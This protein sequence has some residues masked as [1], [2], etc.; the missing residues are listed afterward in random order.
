LTLKIIDTH[1]HL[2]MP[3]FDADREDMIQRAHDAGVYLI[4]TI[5][6]DVE[7]SRKAIELAEQH[8]GI[9][10]SVGIH[11]Q[12]AGKVTKEDIDKLKEF[13]R[14][15]KVVAIGELGLDYYH[16]KTF[17]DS[18]I[19]VLEWE[20]KLAEN[21]HLPIIIHCREAQASLMPVM[22]EWCNSYKIPKG[23]ARGVLHC[24]GS[25]IQTAEWYIERGFYISIGAYVG[26]PSSIQL[27]ETLKSVPVDRLVVETDCPFLPPQKNRGKRNEPA[28]TPITV[29]VLADIKQMTVEEMAERTTNNAMALFDLSSKIRD[30]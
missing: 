6:I 19:K 4:N 23:R 24:F 7:S 26:Y 27:R 28:Y 10:A 20:L 25:D 21:V 11:P 8:S 9:V 15:P 29:G 17:R 30:L 1:A 22:E 5:G 2:D 12:E 18:Q 16:D 3:H 14:H 13:A